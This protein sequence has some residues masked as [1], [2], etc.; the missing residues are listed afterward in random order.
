MKA[1][2]GRFRFRI[3]PGDQVVLTVSPTKRALQAM[4]RRNPPDTWSRAARRILARF[5]RHG[6]GVAEVRRALARKYGQNWLAQ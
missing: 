2:P 6:F 1:R 4:A 3:T 5:E